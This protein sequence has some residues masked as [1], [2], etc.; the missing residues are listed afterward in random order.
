MARKLD[1]G[2]I[3]R[4]VDFTRDWPQ[5]LTGEDAERYAEIEAMDPRFRDRWEHQ[6]TMI[7]LRS[8]AARVFAEAPDNVGSPAE[9]VEAA[10]RI[11]T[12][13]IVQERAEITPYMHAAG[14][15]DEQMKALTVEAIHTWV[16]LTDREREALPY[17]PHNEAELDFGNRFSQ[18]ALT[19][20]IGNAVS[21]CRDAIDNSGDQSAASRLRTLMPDLINRR[22]EVGEPSPRALKRQPYPAMK[23]LPIDK[24]S[25]ALL[26]VTSRDHARLYIN[27][28]VDVCPLKDK[29]IKT[30]LILDEI[31]DGG[32][33]DELSVP[34]RVMFNTCCTLLNDALVNKHEAVYPMDHVMRCYKA[35]GTAAFTDDDIKVTAAEREKAWQWMDEF[36]TVLTIVWQAEARQ[37]SKK[38]DVD[39]VG[40]YDEYAPFVGAIISW[41]REPRIVNGVVKDCLVILDIPLFRYACATGRIDR[42]DARRSV[43]GNGQTWIR[44]ERNVALH[45][46]LYR[47]IVQKRRMK[48]V[49]FAE[50]RLDAIWDH[51]RQMGGPSSESREW[52]DLT[53]FA[54][55]R[56]RDE[57]T[58]VTDAFTRDGLIVGASFSK[59]ANGEMKYL[60]TDFRKATDSE[61]TAGAGAKKPTKTKGVKM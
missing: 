9:M 56:F 26:D 29:T 21:H 57:I 2:I 25:R 39:E 23:A 7:R 54:K 5:Y 18:T 38:K 6:Q 35:G 41:N 59:G 43:V 37:R 14:Y 22:W 16:G 60:R 44:N 53:R 13:I 10:G 33:L 19:M 15:S 49:H 8:S 52:A 1:E 17:V 20:T 61:K 50:F 4:A 27:G 3:K 51:C 28:E 11:A 34:A 36:R 12:G 46:H 58:Q 45:D 24:C 30:K 32:F 48:G 40:L 42:R 31:K 55:K 47:Q